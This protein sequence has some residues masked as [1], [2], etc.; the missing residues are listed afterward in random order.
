M[1][2]DQS[3]LLELAEMVQR[4]DGGDLTRKLLATMLQALV[5]A[6]ATTHIGGAPHERTATRTTQRNGTRDKTVTSIAGDVT[7]KIPKTGPGRSSPRC[8]SRAAA[9][10]SRCTRS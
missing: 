4:A 5:D 7:I 9:S 3:A 2:L 8:S 6:E 10:T 1:A